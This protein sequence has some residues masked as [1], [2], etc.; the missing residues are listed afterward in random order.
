MAATATV[1][2][3]EGQGGGGGGGPFVL[4]GLCVLCV[5]YAWV[6]AGV[7]WFEGSGLLRA[8][9]LAGGWAM[10]TV[11]AMVL[12]HRR[13]TGRAATVAAALVVH[14]SALVTVVAVVLAWSWVRSADW[15]DA[16]ERVRSP[17][18]RFEVVTYDW[19]AMIDP[20]WNLAVERVDGDG[21]EWFWRGTESP[22][23][24]EVRFTGPTSIE[25]VDDHG[26][27]WTVEFDP[28]TLEPSER[29]CTRPE[30][31]HQWPWDEYTSSEPNR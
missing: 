7:L 8:L 5:V 6:G 12:V 28:E 31:C 9:V 18:G 22:A 15:G 11:L 25:V 24:A 21:R 10:A 30:Y 3:E 26:G 27:V 2:T 14:A 29:Y 1:Q 19:Q 23:P 20:G 17:D 13:R 4:V 16:G